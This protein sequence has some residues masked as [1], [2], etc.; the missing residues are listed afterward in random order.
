MVAG[1]KL[2]VKRSHKVE[3]LKGCQVIFIAGSERA[4]IGGILAGLAVLNILTVGESDGFIR[5]GGTIGFLIKGEKLRFEINQEA[6]QRSGLEISSWL[7]KL[8]QPGR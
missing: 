7:L 4:N 2:T 8:G 6:A 5:Q 3:D 1:H